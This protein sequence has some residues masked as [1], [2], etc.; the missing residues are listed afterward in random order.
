LLGILPRL[1]ARL[2]AAMIGVFT[3]LVWLPGVVATPTN[4]LQWTAMLMSWII[5]AAAWV[6]AE[7]LPHEGSPDGVRAPA[8]ALGTSRQGTPVDAR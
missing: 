4:R 8:G 3:A 1:A 5:A 2:E 6:V 7:G